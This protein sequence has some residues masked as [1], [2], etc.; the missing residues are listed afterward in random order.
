MEQVRDLN[1]GGGTEPTLLTTLRLLWV[2]YCP[3]TQEGI[4]ISLRQLLCL[5]LTY[6]KAGIP[7]IVFEKKSAI[8]PPGDRD[9]NMGLHWGYPVLKSLISDEA[10]ALLQTV[11]VDPNTP[12]KAVD[13]LTFLNGSTGEPM[14]SMDVTYF[15]RLRRSKL[16]TLLSQDL[17][18]R[19]N[20]R[21]KNIVYEHD[22]KSVTAIFENG[23]HITGRCLIGA[24][25]ARSNVR[26][27]LLGP[28][29]ASSTRLPYS[30]TFLQ[31]KYTA[32]QAKFLRSFHP[33]YIAA[34]NPDN[35]FAFFGLQDAPS[36]T[37]PEDWTFFFYISWA[38]SLEQQDEERRKFG[39]KERLAQVKEKAKVYC[40]PWK[41][42][43]EWVSEDQPAWYFDL[44]VWDPSL[45]E[46]EWDNRNGRVTLVG[47]AA[48]PMTYRMFL[49]FFPISRRKLWYIN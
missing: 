18:I 48:H 46:H 13:T 45:K 37:N 9:W 20:Y 28:K 2:S 34:P 14:T 43:F 17:D 33:L 23:Q 41:S 32:E 24:D 11:Q 12:T 8:F 1:V 25:G 5:E 29:V 10:F 39:N 7:S 44:S 22:N 38:S 26:Q 30:A 35:T 47:D 4:S 19:Y 16:R 40:E 42:A 36:L 6:L 15:Y 3:R 31:A 21:L 27:L 49:T